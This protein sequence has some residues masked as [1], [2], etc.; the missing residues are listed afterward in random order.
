MEDLAM[1]GDRREQTMETVHTPH[2]RVTLR[3]L[4]TK[5]ETPRSRKSRGALYL[6]YFFHCANEPLEVQADH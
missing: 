2:P 1:N 6:T 4:L 3:S 5:H